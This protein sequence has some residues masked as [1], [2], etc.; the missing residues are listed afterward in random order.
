MQ[1]DE[2]TAWIDGPPRVLA[3]A[4]IGL[5]VSAGPVI[6]YTA[7]VLLK[8]IAAD[9]GWTRGE[10]SLA[11]TCAALATALAAPFV[12][13]LVD[14][15]GG[16]TIARISAMLFAACLAVIAIVPQQLVWFLCAFVLAGVLGSGQTPL[17]YSK[18]VAGAFDRSRGLAL[19]IA[20][21]GM[22]AGAVLLPPYAAWLASD[23]G[24]R[25]AFLGLA[26]AVAI[27]AFVA[28]VLLRA[29]RTTASS[30]ARSAAEF[31][32][33]SVATATIRSALRE[34]YFWILATSFFLVAVGTNGVVGHLAAIVSDAGQPTQ[35][36]AWMV[37]VSGVALIVGRLVGGFLL[38]RTSARFVA[39]GFF[40]AGGLGAVLLSL[41]TEPA[42]AVVGAALI[43]LTIGVETDLI[44]YMISR[45]YGL[46]AFGRLYGIQI[47]CFAFGVGAGPALMGALFDA[48][49]SY[50]FA[51][52]VMS[53]M[54]VAGALLIL[55]IRAQ[56][57]ARNSSVP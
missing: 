13:G 16:A 23:F 30:T 7:S 9:T 50:D 4:T 15:Y 20:L 19:A 54:C 33:P 31:P 51:L 26:I 28:S 34:P 17:S 25:G 2:R 49:G 41:T 32:G 11:I 10:I 52:L 43:G 12:G 14:R 42:V 21:S 44:A 8:P 46:D 18:V 53:A 56:Q 29:Q 55:P 5:S 36:S 37:S 57:V 47:L 45:R 27:V 1:A 35:Q 48:R 40:M 38:D 39:G 22:G 3:G 6:V 24:W